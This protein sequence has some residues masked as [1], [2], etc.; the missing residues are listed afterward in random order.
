M[1]VSMRFAFYLIMAFDI[2]KVWRPYSV[3][4]LGY[5]LLTVVAALVV[6][7]VSFGAKAFAAA[8]GAGERPFI[9]VDSDVNLKVLL[10]TEGLRTGSMEVHVS[11]QPHF[12]REG[13]PAAFEWTDER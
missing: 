8:L 1:R 2:K 12:P 13:L 10:L 4:F 7:H 3:L 5:L 6:A 9:P 11:A